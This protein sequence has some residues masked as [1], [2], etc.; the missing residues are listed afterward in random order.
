[1]VA[2]LLNGIPNASCSPTASRVAAVAYGAPDRADRDR[3]FALVKRYSP[4]CATYAD[5]AGVREMPV[6][7]LGPKTP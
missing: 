2:D 7:W 6:L 5:T 3:L 1:M 4:N